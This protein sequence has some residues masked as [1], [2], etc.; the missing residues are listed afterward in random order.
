MKTKVSDFSQSLECLLGL[1]VSLCSAS[2]CPSPG[3][4]QCLDHVDSRM[5][6]WASLEPSALG[7][8]FPGVPEFPAY[9]GLGLAL[10][11]LLL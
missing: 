7:F 10:F 9:P 5:F 3:Q 1:C 11:R 8:A 4:S 6:T 2:S